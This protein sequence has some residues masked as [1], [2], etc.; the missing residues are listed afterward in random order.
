VPPSGRNARPGS[1]PPPVVPSGALSPRPVL[2]AHLPPRTP[3][4]DH[5]RTPD[6]S[7]GEC[8]PLP[9]DRHAS[10]TFRREGATPRSRPH[11]HLRH[12]HHLRPH[13]SSLLLPDRRH[14]EFRR[15]RSPRRPRLQRQY[16][17]SGRRRRTPPG[18]AM[19]NRPGRPIPPVTPHRHQARAS[20]PVWNQ[21]WHRIRGRMREALPGTGNGRSGD[22]A[23]QQHRKV[24]F[25]RVRSDGP[26]PIP[27]RGKRDD[28]DRNLV[29]IED[30]IETSS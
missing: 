23:P 14:R 29:L 7:T 8:G 25:S 18:H 3:R 30:E 21:R 5:R 9:R 2:P 4:R 20:P 6:R 22:S 19:R 13:R 28:D 11:S 24:G 1:P 27:V 12:L 17:L 16:R 10:T 15:N 26:S